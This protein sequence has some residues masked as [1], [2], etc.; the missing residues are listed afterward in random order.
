MRTVKKFMRCAAVAAAAEQFRLG[1]HVCLSGKLQKD[2]CSLAV[3]LFLAIS[4]L[5]TR[6]YEITTPIIRYFFCV[7]ENRCDVCTQKA[8]LLFRVGALQ[9]QTTR[10]VAKQVHQ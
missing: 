4:F 5:K 2:P 8:P 10:A 9:H 7:S 6:V 1:E 3:N